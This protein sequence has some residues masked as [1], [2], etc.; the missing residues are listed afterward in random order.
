MIYLLTAPFADQFTLFNLF[1][2]QTFRT[3]MA[4]ATALLVVFMIGRPMINWLRRKQGKGQ[5][6]RAD[7]PRAICSPKRAPRPWAGS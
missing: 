3:G 2:Y 5:P 4:L 1:Q 7:G 6:I